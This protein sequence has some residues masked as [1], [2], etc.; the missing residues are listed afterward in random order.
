[1]HKKIPYRDNI[2]LEGD[3]SDVRCL[4]LGGRASDAHL[5]CQRMRRTS[6]F[7][8]K[9]PDAEFSCEHIIRDWKRAC[10]EVCHSRTIQR[11][12]M[13]ALRRNADG[14][15]DCEDEKQTSSESE[16]DCDD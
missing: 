8:S 11:C 15:I 6:A 9:E 5:R 4:Y 10:E 2:A 3:H 16:S 12:F 1:M 14:E 13:R 7:C